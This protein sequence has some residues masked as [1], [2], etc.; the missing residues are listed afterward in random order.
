M[1]KFFTISSFIIVTIFIV[2]SRISVAD[3]EGV[4]VKPPLRQIYSIFM[5]NFQKKNQEKFI[6]DRVK[7]TICKFER[8]I[9]KSWI[10][11]W[12]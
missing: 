9:K 8:P 5:E 1:I 12:I 11:P 7:L 4:R 3:P 6:N 10:R 2:C